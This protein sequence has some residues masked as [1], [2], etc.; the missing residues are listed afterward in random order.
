MAAPN[1]PPDNPEVEEELQEVPAGGLAGVLEQ[2][3]QRG[4]QSRDVD[5]VQVGI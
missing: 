1:P 5:L 4:T 3:C 2:L